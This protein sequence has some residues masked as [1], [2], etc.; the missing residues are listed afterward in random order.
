MIILE[1]PH[2]TGFSALY[3]NHRKNGIRWSPSG[4]QLIGRAELVGGWRNG[5]CHQIK[6]R[7]K[8]GG[9]WK[10]WNGASFDCTSMLLAPQRSTMYLYVL[11]ATTVL[12]SSQK[13]LLMVKM[14]M[15]M[16]ES[17]SIT[18][19]PILLPP[20]S[21]ASSVDRPT[22]RKSIGKS[23]DAAQ[24]SHNRRCGLKYANY[25]DEDSNSQQWKDDSMLKISNGRKV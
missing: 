20:S 5:K 25:L 4:R 22:C 15:R 12:H 16:R 2:F 6:S 17:I 10:G 21:P 8:G 13:A 1:W 23:P 3:R 7:G 19:R 9:S 24:M 18:S 14:A 11:V